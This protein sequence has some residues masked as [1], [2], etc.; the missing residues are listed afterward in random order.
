[1]SDLVGTKV[2]EGTAVDSRRVGW[3]VEVEALGDSCEY[4][5]LERDVEEEEVGC[6]SVHVRIVPTR[7]SRCQWRG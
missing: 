4:P 6:I 3:L 1:M 7:L 5:C 2:V